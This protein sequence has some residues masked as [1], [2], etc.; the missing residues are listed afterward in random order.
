MFGAP[1]ICTAVIGE[2]YVLCS[3]ISEACWWRQT[4]HFLGEYISCALTTMM[5]VIQCTMLPVLQ[6]PALLQSESR[7][8]C[9]P[10]TVTP[11]VGATHFLCFNHSDCL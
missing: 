2:Q 11:V 9:A 3:E 1:T 4:C 5:P 7:M 10:T 6:P 8:Y